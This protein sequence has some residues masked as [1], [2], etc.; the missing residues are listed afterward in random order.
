MSLVLFVLP[1][2]VHRKGRPCNN[3]LGKVGGCQSLWGLHPEMRTSHFGIATPA[4]TYP[5]E[6]VGAAFLVDDVCEGNPYT[7]VPPSHA[8]G[9]S[10]GVGLGVTLKKKYAQAK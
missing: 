6:L 2:I 9:V 3:E 4:A 10:Q 1:I 8:W 7:V 5:C